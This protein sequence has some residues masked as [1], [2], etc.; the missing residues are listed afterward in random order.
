MA[1]TRSSEKWNASKFSKGRTCGKQVEKGCNPVT[2]RTHYV[3]DDIINAWMAETTDSWFV[4]M[5]TWEIQY[6]RY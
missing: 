3:Q 4:F 1:V 6:G 5:R 2:E